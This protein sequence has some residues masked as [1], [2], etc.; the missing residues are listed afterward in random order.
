MTIA[1][2]EFTNYTESIRKALDKIG[3]AEKLAEQTKILIKPNLVEASPPPITT[4]VECT[5][6]IVDILKELSSAELIIGEGCGTPEY[7]TETVF[8]KLGYTALANSENMELINLNTSPLTKL[9]DKNCSVFPEYY[10]PKIAMDSFIVSVPV[11]KAHSLAEVTGSLKNMMGLAP[12]E[13]YQQGGYWKKSAFHAQMQDAII[14]MN[15]YRTPD[16]TIMD[17]TVGLAEFH[18]GGPEC[19]PPVNKIIASFNPKEVDRRAAEILGFN[20]EDIG[21]LE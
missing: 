3:A 7:N 10:I 20:W 21:H 4:P 13:H 19:D 14:E 17:A 6:A 9:E 16:L 1:E 12:P 18:L 8:E 11:L 2:I 5:A 15:K